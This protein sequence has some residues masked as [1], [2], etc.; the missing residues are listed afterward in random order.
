MS[1]RNRLAEIDRIGEIGWCAIEF[2]YSATGPQCSFVAGSMPAARV[3]FDRFR[4]VIQ[5]IDSITQLQLI[6][7]CA[8]DFRL[9]IGATTCYP[10][11][12]PQSSSCITSFTPKEAKCLEYTSG[13]S[14]YMHARFNNVESTTSVQMTIADRYFGEY[15][16]EHS[17]GSPKWFDFSHPG[18]SST[19]RTLIIAHN[20]N[21]WG[22]VS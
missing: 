2:D 22:S 17:R 9:Q 7:W 13:G 19:I 12:W 1:Y 3:Q 6:C 14:L 16:V 15:F 10:S 8:K 21:N 5:C 18:D 4:R 11:A 20:N